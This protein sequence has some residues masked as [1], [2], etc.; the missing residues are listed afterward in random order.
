MSPITYAASLNGKQFQM[1][2]AIIYIVLSILLYWLALYCYK[3]RKLESASEAIAFSNL[4]LLFKYGVT[5]CTMLVGGMYFSKVQVNNAWGWT[6][7]GYIAGAVIG[8]FIAEMVLQKTWRVFKAVKGLAVYFI[9]MFVIITAVKML[10]VYENNIPEQ[11]QIKSVQLANNSS[12]FLN[13]KES[14]DIGFISK[15]L[16]RKENIEAFRKLHQQILHDKKINLKE[17]AYEFDRYGPFDPHETA[18]F[19]YELKDGSK[20][21]REYRINKLLYSDFYKPIFES[22]EYKRSSQ[23]IFN[24]D[25]KKIR[26]ISLAPNGPVNKILT[27]SDPND[28][29]TMISLLKADILAESYEDSIYY[30]QRGSTIDIS[31][32]KDWGIN[33]ELRPSFKKVIKWLKEKGWFDRATVSADDLDYVLIGKNNFSGVKDPNLAM[34]ELEK[35]SGVLKITDQEQMKSALEK[36]GILNTGTY[37]V[38]FKY[39]QGRNSEMYYF[40]DKHVPDFVK[41]QVK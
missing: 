16:T 11:N 7:F 39:K 10:G 26:Y 24:V 13:P 35:Q 20:V 37:A 34:R 21:I 3:K 32:G 41:E 5:F 15:P 33:M 28:V 12:I 4:R 18:Y 9:I 38:L 30:N 40:D 19:V 22:T 23:Q 17:M 27:I 25:E 14:Y 6:I 31:M 1:Q 2:A 8:Y 36:A 29:K